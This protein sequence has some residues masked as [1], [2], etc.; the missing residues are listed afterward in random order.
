MSP[1]SPITLAADFLARRRTPLLGIVAGILF[2]NVIWVT[3][4]Y[5]V[6]PGYLDHGEPSVTL[7]SWRLLDGM[8]AFLGFDEPALTSNIYGPLS[9]AVHAVSFWLLGPSIIAGKAASLLAA[10]L[11]PVLVFLSQ[12]RRGFN[13]AAVGAILA[14]GLVL[15]HVPFSIWNRPDTFLALL[16][17]IAVWAANASDPHRPEWLKTIVIAVAAGLAVGMKI[18][19]GAYFAPVVLFHC[20]NENRGFRT[21]AAMAVIGLTVVFA[22]FAFST[23]SLSAFVDWITMIAKKDSTSVFGSKFVRYGV[24]YST[25]VLFFLADWRW[26]GKRLFLAEKVYFWVFVICL[27]VILFPATK[28]GAGT[29]YFY[30]FLA[31]VIDQVLRHAGRLEVRKA[32]V[33]GLVGVLALA[34]L[35]VGIP[36]QKRF[37]RALHWQETAE[38]QTEIRTIMSD[39]KG[40]SIEMGVGHNVTTYPRTLSRTLL[41]FAGH[42]YSL[43]AAI[44]MEM[45]KWK[46]FLP[47]KTLSALRACKTD[48]WLIPKGERPF[49]MTGYYGTPVLPAIFSET[50]KTRYRKARTYKFFEVWACTR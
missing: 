39:Y 17:V 4:T 19:A 35:I 28:E 2:V 41:V 6:Y 5:L 8:P 37:F 27:V 45:I 12:R 31:I 32:G 26:S 34:I 21:F 14:C 42:P 24:L 7:I 16:G 33:W 20:V 49:M 25:P 18:H 9:Y 30:P 48:L 40:Q 11:I 23:F 22:P 3:M 38:I 1:S 43:D 13:Q 50:F 15:F 47:E 29:H 36:V 46:F 44:A 10:T